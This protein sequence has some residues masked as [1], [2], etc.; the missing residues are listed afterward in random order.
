MRLE[1]AVIILLAALASPLQAALSR[2]SILSMLQARQQQRQQQQQRSSSTQT[3]LQQE[4]A[5][6]QRLKSLSEQQVKVLEAKLP[7]ALRQ[8]VAERLKVL[9]RQETQRSGVDGAQGPNMV[10]S[11]ASSVRRSGASANSLRGKGASSGGAG[12]GSGG[13][14]GGD[15]GRGGGRA[16]AMARMAAMARR[17]MAMRRRRPKTP[18]A[19]ISG[20]RSFSTEASRAL[21]EGCSYPIATESVM[22]SFVAGSGGCRMSAYVCYMKGQSCVDVGMSMMCC[23]PGY[24]SGTLHALHRMKQMQSFISQFN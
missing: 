16:K 12:G 13:G 18:M 11:G 8:K 20:Y 9:K 3:R 15:A 5:I 23:P 4:Q 19:T 17:V 22:E 14:G 2:R 7:P 24:S 10:V 6:F 1:I 21:R